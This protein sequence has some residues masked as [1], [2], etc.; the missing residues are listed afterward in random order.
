[1]VEDMLNSMNYKNF[2]ESKKDRFV[3]KD[4]KFTKAEIIKQLENWLTQR[5]GKPQDFFDK[6]KVKED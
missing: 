3:T 6:N 2:R 5:L 4:G 1:M